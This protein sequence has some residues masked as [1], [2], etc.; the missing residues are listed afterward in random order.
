MAFIEGVHHIYT[1]N[2]GDTLY[3]IAAR[4]GSTVQLIEQTN[5]LYPPITDPGLIYPGQLLVIPETGVG[6]RTAVSYMVH[7][8]DTLYTIGLRFSATPEMLA[9]INPL[10]TNPNVIRAGVPIFVPA[11]IYQVQSGQSLFGI[12][13]R[14]GIPM[15]EIVRAN[16]NRPGFSPDVLYEGYRLIVPMPSSTNIVVFKPEPGARIQPGQALEGEARAFEAV[17]LY[18]VRDDRDVVVTKEKAIMTTAGAP[19]FGSF[20]TAILFD[21]Q[22]TAPSGELWVYARSARDGRIIDLVQVKVYF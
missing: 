16:R 7:Y 19:A 12:S 11:L 8:G 5:A 18:Q 20:S 22:P 10:I 9:G 13:R 21:R 14:L 1:V 15:K 17:V 2:P 3:T 4:F 6:Q